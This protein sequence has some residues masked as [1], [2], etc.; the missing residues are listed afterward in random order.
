MAGGY[1]LRSLTE[2]STGRVQEVS[3]RLDDGLIAE[4][5]LLVG[6]RELLLVAGEAEEQP[7]GQLVWHRLDESVLVFTDPD[8]VERVR[9]VPVRGLLRT[10]S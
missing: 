6:D 3:V 5:S 2:L 10:M 9:W 1:R 4:V 8:E 7:S